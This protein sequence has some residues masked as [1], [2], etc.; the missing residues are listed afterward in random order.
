MS[1][2]TV[3][4]SF[5][6]PF[7]LLTPVCVFLGVASACAAGL[8]VHYF[9]VLLAGLGALLAHIAVN[10]LNEYEDFESGLDL[11]TLRTPFSG[12]S[13]ALPA[14]HGSAGAV[15]IAALAALAGTV[16][17]G[18]YF[19][20]REGWT[21]LGLGLPG[22]LLIVSYTRWLNQVPWL[23]L[24]APGAGF[25]ISMV[26]GTQLAVAGEF[27]RVGFAAALL[28]FFLVNNL[29]LLNQFP[30]IEA[31]RSVGRNHFSIAYGARAGAWAYGAIVVAAVVT[32]VV[33]GALRLFPMSGYWLVLA[34]LPG[35]YVAAGAMRYGVALGAHTHYLAVNVAMTLLVPL[36]LGIL[37][38]VSA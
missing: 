29:L 33:A 6:P 34:L 27:S 12:G 31:D 32:V 15:R 5:R 1:W 9:Q 19:L 22:V 11:K 7:L 17:I 30:D 35:F 16:A 36:L 25:G 38:M 28:E 14:D 23:C 24:V 8:Q 13:G 2:H 3:L 18:L 10:A 20:W 37:L 4:R 26:L 21:L